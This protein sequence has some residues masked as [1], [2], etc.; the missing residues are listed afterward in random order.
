MPTAA[1]PFKRR[2]DTNSANDTNSAATRVMMLPERVEVEAQLV[3]CIDEIG[4]DDR[5]F[6]VVG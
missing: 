4:R 1:A 5:T 6:V 2:A 3:D